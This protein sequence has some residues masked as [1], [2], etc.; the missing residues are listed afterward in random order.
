[1]NALIEND[2]EIEDIE[3]ENGTIMIYGNPKDL[4]A[5]KTAISSSLNINEFEVDEISMLPKEKIVLE[6][7]DLE[8]F[9]RVYNMLDEVEDVQHIY[10]NVEL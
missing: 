3:N 9:K 5:I 4:F 7:E 2:C 6:G 1:M 8:L 10:H